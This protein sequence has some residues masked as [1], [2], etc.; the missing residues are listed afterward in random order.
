MVLHKIPA[1]ELPGTANAVVDDRDDAGMNSGSESSSDDDDQA[2]SDWV[3]DDQNTSVRSL[4]DDTTFP[5]TQAALEYD[6]E[7]YGFDLEGVCEGLSALR[8]YAL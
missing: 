2:F 3:S 1:S 4:F 7:K 5:K 8:T 6:K